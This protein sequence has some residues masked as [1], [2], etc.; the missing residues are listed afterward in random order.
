MYANFTEET[1]TGTGVTLT[2]A[3]ATTDNLAFSLSYVD[4][5]LVAYA[6]EDSGGSIKIT[7]IGTYNSGANT[8]TRSDTYNYNGTVVDKNP[9][10]NITLSG[11]T[12][13]VRCDLTQT[14]IQNNAGFILEPMTVNHDAIPDNW[15]QIG[16]NG[17]TLNFSDGVAFIPSYYA[18]PFEFNS[19]QMNVVTGSAT[20]VVQAGICTCGLDGLPDKIIEIVTV[21]VT[22]AANVVTSLSQTYKLP[23]GR[24]FTFSSS[25]DLTAK[26]WNVE[27]F[28]HAMRSG[29][30]VYRNGTNAAL[31][32]RIASV[33]GIITTPL[34]PP[35]QAND[36]IQNIM[37]LPRMI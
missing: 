27:M 35:D 15:I 20:D 23:A 8:I 4:G 31:R 19:L 32:S 28:T 3:G 6:V 9:S 13:T 30:Y 26:L 34:V 22:T 2:L 17:R 16:D 7:G 29:S 36:P 21:D 5:D 33:N 11:G 24:Y 18:S 1:C 37:V 25:K 12:H 10:T 14:E